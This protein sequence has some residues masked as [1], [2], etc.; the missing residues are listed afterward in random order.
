MLAHHERW[1]GTGYP[2]EL[3]GKEMP[4]PARII[5]IADAY[6]AMVSDRPYRKGLSHE[7]AITE[8]RACAGSQLD[9]DVVKALVEMMNQDEAAGS[10]D[11]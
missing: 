2:R 1:D 3:R 7:D 6:D 9:P 10:E 4:L 11:E 5:A 8:I